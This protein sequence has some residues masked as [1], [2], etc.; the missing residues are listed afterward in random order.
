[1]S[2][3]AKDVVLVSAR[4][5]ASH[6]ASPML[7]VDGEGTLVFLNDAAED[8]LGERFADIGELPLMAWGQRFLPDEIEATPMTELPLAVAMLERRPGHSSLTIRASGERK[9]IQVTAYPLFNRDD[10]FVG[11]AAIFWE[12]SARA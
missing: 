6:V 9:T 12:P 7:L 2:A 10:T 8:L 1:M 4:Q 5:L 3:A 11:A